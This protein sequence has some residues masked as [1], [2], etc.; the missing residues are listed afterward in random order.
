MRCG[1]LPP[2]ALA[3]YG[4]TVPGLC[5]RAVDTTVSC[6]FS[7]AFLCMTHAGKDCEHVL[8]NV[9]FCLRRKFSR[10]K[11]GMRQTKHIFQKKE[12]A[13]SSIAEPAGAE[14]HAQLLTF[15]RGHSGIP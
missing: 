1:L 9:S 12:V 5:C 7:A 14:K 3:R 2:K 13:G 11:S 4:L 8:K 15:H 10:I 6:F